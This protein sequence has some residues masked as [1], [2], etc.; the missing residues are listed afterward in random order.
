MPRRLLSIT[1]LISLLLVLL[2]GCGREM[3]SSPPHITGR[4]KVVESERMSVPNSFFWFSM[5]YLEFHGDGEVWALVRWPPGRQNESEL[6]LN[7]TGRYALVGQDQIEFP[8]SCRHQ[9]P[10]AGT[11]T[12]AQE[13]DE[14]QI[15]AAESRLHLQWTAPPSQARPPAIPGPSASPTPVAGP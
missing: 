2:A 4:W 7:K 1:T 12:L 15:S 3:P 9:D 11:Y 14:L 8:G 13:G 10:C 6:R 5:D